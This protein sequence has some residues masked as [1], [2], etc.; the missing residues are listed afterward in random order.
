MSTTLFLE[1]A[2]NDNR[3]IRIAVNCRVLNERRGGPARYTM[4]V[5]RE[6]SRIDRRNFYTLIV[7]DNVDLDFPLP[8]NFSI[9]KF[10]IR[11]KILFDYIILPVYSY[12]RSF[13]IF[14]FP[15]NTFSPLIRGKKIP[16]YHDI[17]YFEKIGFREFKF[18]DNL[19][20]TVMIPVAAKFAAV[21]LTVSD[22]TASRMRELLGIPEERIAVIKEGVE[23][24]FRKIRNRAFL[25]KVKK[26]HGIDKKFFFYSGSLSPR[27]N[28]IGVLRAFGKVKDS[29]PHDIFITGGDS[30]LDSE[31]TAL[32]AESGFQERVHRLG[33]ID[34]E[35]LVAFYNLADCYLYPS[36]Y[37][38]F[39]LPILE[40]QRCGCPVI[41]SNVSSCPE[42]AGEGAMYVDPYSVDELA[43]AMLAVAG[44]GKLRR[45]LV[46]KGDAN[47][48]RF[49]W[50]HTA[51][52]ILALMERV[53]RG[54]H[55]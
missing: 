15:K 14:L 34:D 42:V 7:Y 48:A 46:K 25:E 24:K 43:G 9:K 44:D 33:Y 20:H 41:T 54:D 5:I 38:G 21:N 17:I 50:K 2:M 3:P 4:N 51:S 10:G 31:V 18:F 26:R 40:A 39:G 27:K 19:H 29:I 47:C 11:S 55:F 12:F 1:H 23:P 49:T 30:W 45:R 22:F 28:I 52:G 32:I 16:V 8:E 6:L 13:D 37:E 53:H 35:E 36:L